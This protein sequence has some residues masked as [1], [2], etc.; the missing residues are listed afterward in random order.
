[1]VSDADAALFGF[2]AHGAGGDHDEVDALGL[3]DDGADHVH[4][5]EVDLATEQLRGR[6]TGGGDGDELDVESVLVE[7]AF[8]V[9]G[10]RSECV[11]A[12]EHGDADRAV[13]FGCSIAG[14]AARGQREGGEHT[15]C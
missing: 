11:E 6:F 9:G 12:G 10:P 15:G 13:R 8:E 2:G 14:P 7:H 4:E 3:G 5:G 1:E